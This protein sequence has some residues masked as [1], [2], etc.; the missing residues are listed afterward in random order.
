MQFT[1]EQ[2]LQHQLHHEA[3][4]TKCCGQHK[5]PQHQCLVPTSKVPTKRT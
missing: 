1:W 2:P 5:A 3:L 4:H